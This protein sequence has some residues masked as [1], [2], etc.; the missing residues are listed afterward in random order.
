M[1][2]RKNNE[3]ITLMY[4]SEQNTELSKIDDLITVHY[5][6][7]NED[8]PEEELNF[9]EFERAVALIWN[10]IMDGSENLSG[11]SS[12][13]TLKKWEPKPVSDA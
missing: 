8:R 2:L 13:G 3:I 5:S 1:K 9:D 12:Q 7:M 11:H 10:A 4:N 6:S